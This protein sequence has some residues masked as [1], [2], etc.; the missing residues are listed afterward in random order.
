MIRNA[1]IAGTGRYLERAFRS[2]FKSRSVSSI[3]ECDRAGAEGNDH[4]A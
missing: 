4:Q 2:S 1:L 3:L